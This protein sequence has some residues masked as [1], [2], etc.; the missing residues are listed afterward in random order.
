MRAQELAGEYSYIHRLMQHV[1]ITW[2]FLEE[3]EHQGRD[4]IAG[5]LKQTFYK[6]LGKLILEY[7]WKSTLCRQGNT[8]ASCSEQPTV[9]SPEMPNSPAAGCTLISSCRAPAALLQGQAQSHSTAQFWI[10]CMAGTALGR[11]SLLCT[12]SLASL[13]QFCGS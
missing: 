9:S 4:Y 3:N 8:T 7:S 6:C 5:H 11:L 12:P 13:W 10:C 1:L 2:S